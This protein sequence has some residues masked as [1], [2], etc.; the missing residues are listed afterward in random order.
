[1]RLPAVQKKRCESCKKTCGDDY[2]LPNDSRGENLRRRRAKRREQHHQRRFANTNAPLRDGHDRGDFGQ[3]PREEPYAQREIES[4]SNTQERSEQNI[5]ALY[6]SSQQPTKN[7]PP[8]TARNRADR[9]TKLREP[10]PETNRA[11]AQERPLQ[12]QN[13]TKENRRSKDT[14]KEHALRRRLQ[15]N[16]QGTGKQHQA[17]RN[18]RELSGHIE[19]AVRHISGDHRGRTRTVRNSYGEA[20]HVAA[21]NRWQKERAEQPAGVALRAGGEGKLRARGIHHRVPLGDAAGQGQQINQQHGDEARERNAR[22][23]VSQRLHR[24]QIKKNSKNQQRRRPA[25]YKK[26][27]APAG[28][29]RLAVCAHFRKMVFDGNTSDAEKITGL[30]RSQKGPA[31][32]LARRFR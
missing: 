26:N 4:T 19:K 3:W 28:F 25:R 18:E 20:R 8:G 15:R 27:P 32:E 12:R 9:V 29:L 21:D 6:G 14:G 17:Q 30:F 5:G 24:E 22:Q 13:K 2:A 16:G 23:R 31:L 7:Q 11:S 10:A 1:M